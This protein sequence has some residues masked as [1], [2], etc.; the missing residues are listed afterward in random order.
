MSKIVIEGKKVLAGKVRVHGAKNSVLPILAATVLNGG[1][2]VIYDCPRIKDVYS[3][4]EILR[5][6]GCTYTWE[7]NKLTVNS[8]NVFCHH[9][10]ESLMSEMRSSVIFLGALVARCKKALISL[11]GG[12]NLGDRPIDMHTKAFAELGISIEELHGFIS[13]S[14]DSVKPTDLHLDFP[15][16]GATENIMLVACMSSGT[17]KIYNAAREPEIADLAEFLNSAGANIKGAGTPVIEITGVESLR[18]VS[19]TLIPDRIVASTY[20]IAAAITGGYIE[21]QNVVYEHIAK[22]VAVLRE[23]GC[24][25]DYFNGSIILRSN[26]IIKPIDYLRTMPHPGFPTDA[27]P[28]IIALLS[29]ANGTSIIYENI[30]DNRFTHVTELKKMGA[31][32]KVEGRLA[33]IKG[34]DSLYGA[35]VTAPD[36]RAGAALAIAALAANG[37]TE[38]NDIHHIERGYENF[39]ENLQ[40]LGAKIQLIN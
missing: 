31:D 35:K 12:C 15:S 30:F 17:T 2:N 13:A 22:V 32:I 23:S 6:I 40:T 18:N 1:Q 7:G 19:H 4:L 14:C 9:I 34:V 8:E 37:T 38:I 24:S 33:V 5:H 21:I 10:P 3:S 26:K 11:P 29:I 36:L 20:M 28:Q 27:S 25:V 16:V 39:V